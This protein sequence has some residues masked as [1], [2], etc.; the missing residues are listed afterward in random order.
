MT[1]YTSYK[2]TKRQQWLQLFAYPYKV[3]MA[4]GKGVNVLVVKMRK[5]FLLRLRRKRFK[6]PVRRW[7]RIILIA[8]D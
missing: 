4:K 3:L 8:R 7:A 2:L 6:S 5:C 1:P